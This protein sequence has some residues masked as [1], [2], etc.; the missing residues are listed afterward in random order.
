M[1]RLCGESSEAAMDLSGGFPVL[2]KL[3]Y[4]T[5]HHIV[6]KHIHWLLLKKYEIPT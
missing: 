3:K 5:R 6:G 1:C 4:Q 2:A